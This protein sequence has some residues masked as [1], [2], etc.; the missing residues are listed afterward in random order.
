[1]TMGKLF[2]MEFSTLPQATLDEIVRGRHPFHTLR[3]EETGNTISFYQLP[4]NVIVVTEVNIIKRDGDK[5]HELV[6]A[7]CQN[8]QSGTPSSVSRL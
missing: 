7:P 8:H 5:K 1:M 2:G 3:E 4:G 6:R